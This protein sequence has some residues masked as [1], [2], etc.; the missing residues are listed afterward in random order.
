[1]LSLN[2]SLL[3]VKVIALSCPDNE[4][5]VRSTAAP[6]DFLVT[7]GWMHDVDEDDLDRW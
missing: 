7:D 3:D 5:T 4:L 6:Y 1:M 2:P